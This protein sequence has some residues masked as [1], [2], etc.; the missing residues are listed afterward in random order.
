MVLTAVMIML[1]MVT[2]ALTITAVSRRITERYSYFIGLYDLAVSGNEKALFLLQQEWENHSEAAAAR[3]LIR[4]VVENPFSFYF[5]GEVF[6]LTAAARD[7]FHLFFIQEAFAGMYSAMS[8]VFPSSTNLECPYILPLRPQNYTRRMQWRIRTWRIFDW[9]LNIEIEAE[10]RTIIDFYRAYV[11]MRIS[12]ENDRVIVRT[13]V[14][15]CADN[16]PGF[17]AQVSASLIWMPSGYKELVLNAHT[18]NAFMLEDVLIPIR[19]TPGSIIIL[20]EFTL[21]MIESLRNDISRRVQW[22]DVWRN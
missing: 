18:I 5:T 8:I 6:H 19:P 10:E 16:V 11:T 4:V 1:V 22:E 9:H 3:A 17:P 2:V 14:R 15:K 21:T 7:R 20:D 12:E 13:D